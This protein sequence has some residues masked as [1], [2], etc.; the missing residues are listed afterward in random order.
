M[1]HMLLGLTYYDSGHYDNASACFRNALF[2]LKVYDEEHDLQE[3]DSAESDFAL[4]WYLLG[5]C[6]LRMNDRSNAERC[7][8]YTQEYVGPSSRWVTEMDVNAS[9]NVLMVI[10]TGRGPFKTPYGPNA[11]VAKLNPIFAT[12]ALVPEVYVDG[13]VA[14]KP[15]LLLDLTAISEKKK[16]QKLDTIRYVKNFLNS[17]LLVAQ[18]ESFGDLEKAFAKGLNL[19]AA[20]GFSP[21]LRYWEMLPNYVFVL[22]MKLDPG[23][24]AV[25]LVFCDTRGSEHPWHRQ[26]W[27]R[28]SIP[29]NGDR[30]LWFRCG[31]KVSDGMM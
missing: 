22:P 7:F 26:E 30:L 6:R 15:A 13:Q 14:P 3:E 9:S 18:A 28:V 2:K 20:G 31:P 8:Q 29:E 21:D 23:S 10:E 4:G 11:V 24:H 12:R 16:W 25:R 1:A 19:V 5:R 27:M 17:G